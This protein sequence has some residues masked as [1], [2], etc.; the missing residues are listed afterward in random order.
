MEIFI[1]MFYRSIG[2]INGLID[3]IGCRKKK[4]KISGQCNSISRCHEGKSKENEN[5]GLN[6]DGCKNSEYT[7]NDK[8]RM[9]RQLMKLERANQIHR[10][11][12]E[13]QNNRIES[14]MKV[15]EKLKVSR[16]ENDMKP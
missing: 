4:T 2:R 11:R 10:I 9:I 6:L 7:E 15:V 12:F 1:S 14:L 13:T 16:D 5:E 3:R 8:C